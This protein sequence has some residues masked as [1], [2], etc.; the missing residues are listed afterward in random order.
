MN[1]FFKWITEF[2]KE[3]KIIKNKSDTCMSRFIT[4]SIS[5]ILRIS[6]IVPIFSQLKIHRN[7]HLRYHFLY[8][9]IY[10]D[11]LCIFLQRKNDKQSMLTNCRILLPI[12]ILT[13]KQ[14]HKNQ[15]MYSILFDLKKLIVVNRNQLRTFIDFLQFIQ[16][17]NTG[18][19]KEQSE[20]IERFLKSHLSFS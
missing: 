3:N 17:H 4:N 19:L 20:Q 15:F 11:E 6:F 1:N 13:D 18:A 9:N 10:Y 5:F 16:N 7:A 12:I 2:Y 8:L 14:K